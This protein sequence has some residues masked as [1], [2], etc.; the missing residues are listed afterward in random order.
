MGKQESSFFMIFTVSVWSSAT[1]ARAWKIYRRSKQWDILAR[2]LGEPR[3]PDWLSITS[4]SVK[5]PKFSFPHSLFHLVRLWWFNNSHLDMAPLIQRCFT[6]LCPCLHVFL[7]FQYDLLNMTFKNL[8][9]VTIAS[10]RMKY[11]TNEFY[12]WGD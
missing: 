11:L 5:D 3:I 12:Q 10:K 9:T 7:Y 6:S 4:H 8:C 2:L 1:T